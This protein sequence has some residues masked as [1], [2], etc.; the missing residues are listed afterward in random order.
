MRQL[1]LLFL[2]LLAACDANA[3][4][5]AAEIAAIANN[6]GAEAEAGDFPADPAMPR[7]ERTSLGPL[8][9][10]YDAALLAPVP[11]KVALPP[12]WK[13][14]VDG[15]KLLARDRAALIGR[16]E[17][18]YGQSDQASRCNVQQEAGLSFAAL[19]EDFAAF[20]GRLPADQLEP[21]TLAG[22]QGVSWQIGA[23]G[24]GAEYILLPV[25]RGA[26]LIVRQFRI[27]GN[28]DETALGAVLNDLR[29][30]GAE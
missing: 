15:L 17:C 30:T 6:V 4:E 21:V 5:N 13:R 11:A 7:P 29:I 24:E 22:A 20:R 14:E 26:I 12:D 23:E 19:D 10:R 8:Q 18:M 2:V 28:P 9:I 25:K 1:T 3:P 16:A 27:S